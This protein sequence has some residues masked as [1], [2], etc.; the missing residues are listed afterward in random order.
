MNIIKNKYFWIASI[1]II[2][3][4]IVLYIVLRP[5]P[6]SIPCISCSSPG[7]TCDTKTG[8]CVCKPGYYS[9]DCSKICSNCSTTGGTCDSTGKCICNPGY[10]SPD[11]SKTCQTCSSPGGICDSAGKCLCGH[12]YFGDS[13][14]VKCVVDPGGT[15]NIETKE[16]DCDT[17]YFKSDC[18]INCTGGT[19]DDKLEKC[20]I[21]KTVTNAVWPLVFDNLLCSVPCYYS[22][23]VPDDYGSIVS[24]VVSIN[25]GIESETNDSK[26]SVTLNQ[27]NPVTVVT[28]IIDSTDWID[29]SLNTPPYPQWNDT[30]S[31]DLSVYVNNNTSSILMRY[32]SYT[33]QYYKK[34]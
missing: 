4:G 13:C 30:T 3:I 27:T 19:Y 10:Y 15:Y 7:G 25:L 2:V 33:L 22:I 32:I 34:N 26:A 18:S 20:V 14:D 8:T 6:K 21:T 1:S 12:D 23:K 5:S 31:I 9:P 16:C 11:C 24:F 29:L 28:N 17:G